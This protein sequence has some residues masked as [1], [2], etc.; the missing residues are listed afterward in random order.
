MKLAVF[1][2]LLVLLAALVGFPMSGAS[3]TD[4]DRH[5]HD[6]RMPRQRRHR[7]E[8]PNIVIILTDDQDLLLGS[9]KV[10]PKLRR[11][12]IDEGVTMNSSF[13]T[14]P[15]CCPSRSSILTGMYP[16]NHHVYTNNDN[17]SS[18]MWRNVHE[19]HIF[20]NY[21]SD[22][23]YRTGYFGK[24]LNEYDG[25]YIPPGWNEWVGLI[26]NSRFY[27]YTVNFNGMKIKHGD[28]YYRDYLTDLIA[29]DSVTFLKQSKQYYPSQPVLMV[30]STPAPHGPEDAAP[31]YQHMF[32]NNTDHHTP[33]WNHA[34]N[35]DKQWL[36]QVTDPM[37]P[38][39]KKFTNLLQR[40]RLQTLQSVDDLIEKVYNELKSLGEL[41]NTYIIYT[42]DHGYHLGQY[43]LV[44]G[45]AMPYEFDVHVPLILRG[46]GIQPKSLLNNIV[47]NVDLAPTILDIAGVDIP[48]HMD[49][50][51]ILK[52]IKG[53][54]D[55]ANVDEQHF[56]K[57]KKTLRDTV[58]LE[59]GKVTP[60]QM[61]VQMRKEKDMFWETGGM[62]W[63]I[64]KLVRKRAECEKSEFQLPCKPSQKWFC[65]MQSG[66]RYKKQK[67][68]EK[69]NHRLTQQDEVPDCSC[70]GHG[71]KI[72]RQERKKQRKFIRSHVKKPDFNPK[73]LRSRRSISPLGYDNTN[74]I[75]LKMSSPN[76]GFGGFDQLFN[77][78]CRVLPNST[79]SCDQQLYKDPYAWKDHKERLDEMIVEYRKVLEDLRFIRRHLKNKKPNDALEIDLGYGFGIDNNE[80]KDC[81]CEQNSVIS[82]KHSM[83]KPAKVERMRKRVKR[84]RKKMRKK[85]RGS[86]CNAP[87][88]KC[89]THS[90][91]H[92]RTPPL[93][94]DGPFCFCPNANNNTYWC[95]RT[96]NQTHNFLYC[97]F[98]TGFINYYNMNKDPYQ[99]RNDIQSLNYGVL[100]QLHETLAYMKACKGSRSCSLGQLHNRKLSDS[101]KKKESRKTEHIVEEE[102]LD[103][104]NVGQTTI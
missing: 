28:N 90:D 3:S 65:T 34:P 100:Q 87:S 57:T 71:K 20:A 82:R 14:T 101:G 33:S 31:Q 48:P 47:I 76:I 25:S 9:L 40:R 75:D 17:C 97:E 13:V 79:I 91:D 54:K 59:R 55:P 56:V 15:M 45:K 77:R 16:H 74:T 50:R 73:F 5:K 8:K 53:A 4:R 104:D 19:P 72:N 1:S 68:R 81:N 44:K 89:F 62:N 39:H 60:K 7:S 27:N 12:L 22:Q 26:R 83:I 103:D 6:K 80:G 51:S 2:V 95:L 52:V 58:L 94:K 85:G 63:F 102:I 92:W 49:G 18:I 23:G 10:M 21:L 32:V 61:K 24:Y 29:N 36:L 67:C 66:G 69:V 37:A 96:V 70:V 35:P 41:D 46:P 93:W 88:M 38:L 30:L 84:K 78:R 86:T 11:L 64:P 42:S 43:G 98:I 99:L